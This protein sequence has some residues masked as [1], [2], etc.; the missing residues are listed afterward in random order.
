VRV[1][2]SLDVLRGRMGVEVGGGVMGVRMCDCPNANGV[3]KDLRS[4]VMFYVLL[5]QALL[6]FRS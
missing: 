3:A 6:V 5:T 4:C 2:H 1:P